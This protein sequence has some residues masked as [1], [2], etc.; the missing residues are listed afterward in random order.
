MATDKKIQHLADTWLFNSC[1]QRELQHIARACDEVD[2]KEGKELIT[3][4]ALG[5]EMFVIRQGEATVKRNGRKITTLGPGGYFGELSILSSLP[6]NSTVVA[7]SDMSLLVLGG[8]EFG[9]LLDE[10]PSITHKLLSAMAKR[11]SEQDT[12][13]K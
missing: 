12:K 6:R 7:A 1:N 2:V 13:S 5:R 11:L 4:G 9:A 10:V 8:R 3:Q